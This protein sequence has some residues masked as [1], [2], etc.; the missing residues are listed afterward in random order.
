VFAAKLRE[1]EQALQPHL[2]WP[3]AEAIEAGDEEFPFD[4]LDMVQP[5]LFAVMVSLAELWRSLGVEPSAVIGQSQGEVPAAYVAGALSLEDAARVAALRSRVLMRIAGK[6]KMVSVGIGADQLAPLLRRWDGRIEVATVA[7]PS[8]TGVAGD[9]D[10]L[11]ELI[12]QCTEEGVRA[13]EIPGVVCPSHSSHVDVL[14]DEILEVLEPIA[15]RSGDV[16]F[17]STVSGELIDTAGMDAEYWYRNLRQPVLL[18]PVVRSLLAAGQRGFIEV[19]PHPVIAFGVRETIDDALEGEEALVVGTLRRGEGGPERFMRS[20]AEAHVGGVEIDWEL[21]FAGR[22]ARQVELP[23]YPFQRRRFWVEPVPHVGDL[24]AAGQAYSEHSLLSGE[25]DLAGDPGALLLTGRI[26]LRANPWLADHRVLGSVALPPAVFL[27]LALHGCRRAGCGRIDALE[28]ADPLFLGDEDVQLQVS[29]ASGD[30]GGRAI[31]IHSRVVGETVWRQHATGSLGSGDAVSGT[32]P[33]S[34]GRTADVELLR[35]HRGRLADTGIERGAAFE[36]LTAVWHDEEGLCAEAS[37]SAAETAR[38]EGFELHPALWD[39]AF[40]AAAIAGQA[41]DEVAGTMLPTGWR[42]VRLHGGGHHELFVEVDDAG[43]NGVALRLF[44]QSGALAAEVGALALAQTSEAALRETWGDLAERHRIE[45]DRWAG[46]PED[47]L[48]DADGLRDRLAEMSGEEREGALLDLVRTRLAAVLGH[49]SPEEIDPQRVFQELGFDSIMA[50]ELRNRLAAATGLRLPV[51]ALANHP[52]AAGLAGYLSG[53]F[54]SPLPGGLGVAPT[55]LASRLPEALESGQLD[56]FL[57]VLEEEARARPSFG[58][59][60]AALQSHAPVR[61]ASGGV[62][63][64]LVLIPSMT[65][66]SGPHEY[67][68]LARAFEGRRAAFAASLPGFLAEEALPDG[69]E[70]AIEVVVEAIVSA[71]LSQAPVLA[72]YSSGGWLAHAVAARMEERGVIPDAV[73][74]LDTYLPDSAVLTAVMPRLLELL[75]GVEADVDG[76]GLDDNRLTAMVA[77]LQMFRDW[78]PPPIATPTLLVR[79]GEPAWDPDTWQPASWP[80]VVATVDAAGDHFSLMTDHAEATAAS[81]AEALDVVRVQST[82]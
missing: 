22:G 21:L 25:V 51:L 23:T 74:L 52:T 9:G 38:A 17:H 20:L 13:K 35:S 61:L 68:R 73:V 26:S 81:I 62:E 59:S 41:F 18:D 24:A 55:V 56:G 15:P 78:Q 14:R 49:G 75:G 72:G 33:R 31:E 34:S 65:P 66:V 54:G 1:C 77:Y 45:L 12:A 5:L 67:A 71:D 80:D 58:A 36:A 30:E 42:D 79:C 53:L 10:A 46:T 69:V 48:P 8:L 11:D 47:E 2:S 7:G 37:L 6:G 40:Q 44:D 57:S 3:F 82:H 43:T 76:I 27:D 29:I 28:L 60:G 70:T 19:G 4:R 16:P 39:A 63:P 32:S 50:V 64:A